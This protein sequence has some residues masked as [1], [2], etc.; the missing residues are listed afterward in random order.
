MLGIGNYPQVFPMSD[1]PV[2]TFLDTGKFGE[3]DFQTYFV[4]ERCQPKVRNVRYVGAD[5][6]KP[7]E[8]FMKTLQD[9]SYQR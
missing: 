2:R 8:A 5:Q 9:T 6:A 7:S 3:L 4:R 1:D